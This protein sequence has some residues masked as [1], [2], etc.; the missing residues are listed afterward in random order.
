MV[1]I[2]NCICFG[3]EGECMIARPVKL[4]FASVSIFAGSLDCAFAQA[5]VADNYSA[6]ANAILSS[7]SRIGLPVIFVLFV[8]I[9][10]Y[11]WLRYRKEKLLLAE[12][13]KAARSA[14]KRVEVTLK[15]NGFE[16]SET[17][18]EATDG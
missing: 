6:I 3:A 17:S 9:F 15:A 14:L 1:V 4:I 5:L 2:Y 7:S 11:V 16:V 10:F 13:L 12:K 18:I 8:V